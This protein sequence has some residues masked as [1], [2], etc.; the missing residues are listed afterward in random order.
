MVGMNVSTLALILFFIY[1]VLRL[2]VYW[3]LENKKLNIHRE[4]AC[5]S[6]NVK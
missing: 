2:S 3:H 6:K 1:N 5:R 4:I